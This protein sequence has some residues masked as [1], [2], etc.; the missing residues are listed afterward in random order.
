MVL[1]RSVPLLLILGASSIYGAGGSDTILA[2]TA[3]S[4]VVN[5]G[6]L[7]DSIS[8]AALLT[9]FT[10]SGGKGAD[11]II[12]ST[13]TRLAASTVVKV[14]ILSSLK[15]RRLLKPWVVLVPIPSSPTL[16]MAPLH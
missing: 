3:D 1:T 13:L 16:L 4:L 12:L 15:V 10:V 2:R 8:V 14:K 9:G 6:D 7:G 5:G 11:T